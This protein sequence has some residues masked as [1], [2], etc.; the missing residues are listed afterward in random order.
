MFYAEIQR[1]VRFTILGISKQIMSKLEGYK[2]GMTY[3]DHFCTDTADK[4]FGMIERGDKRDFDVIR[5]ELLCEEIDRLYALLNP[6]EE[7]ELGT[8]MN[9]NNND[10]QVNN[11]TL[12]KILTYVKKEQLKALLA[13]EDGEGFGSARECIEQGKFLALT[14]LEMYIAGE[15]E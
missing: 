8:Q 11:K 6:P 14:D 9:Q 3:S 13:S 4:V 1:V 10:I 5:N 7:V 15:L 2:M 12:N